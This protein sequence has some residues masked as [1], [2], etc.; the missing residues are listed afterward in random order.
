MTRAAGAAAALAVAAL[1]GCGGNARPTPTNATCPSDSTLTYE[2]FGAPFME[3]YCTRC[4]SSELRG[5]DRHGA[6]LYHDFDS[7]GGI[8]AVANHVDWYTAAGPDAI[9]EIMPPDGDTPTLDER[10]QLGE[11]LACEVDQR[12]HPPDAGVPDAGMPDGGLV[13]AG[14]PD[15]AP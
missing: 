14:V 5:A 8:V 13:D 4:H 9:N 3:A 1:V 15:A 7:L 2:N 6:P 11:W 10:Y 12:L